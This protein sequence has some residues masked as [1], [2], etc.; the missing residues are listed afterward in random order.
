MQLTS[1]HF[2]ND[3]SPVIQKN[4]LVYLVSLARLL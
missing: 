4:Q 1:A 3:A 2:L